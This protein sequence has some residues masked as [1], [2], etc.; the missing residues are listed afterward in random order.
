MSADRSDVFQIIMTILIICQKQS[1]LRASSADTPSHEGSIVS[2]MFKLYGNTPP[3]PSPAEE[4]LAD[5]K[6]TSWPLLAAF[7]ET[8]IT[9]ASKPP[10]DLQPICN[11]NNREAG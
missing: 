5:I 2:I 9:T 11:E 7:L 4:P 1:E 10:F 8:H 6:V 3:A